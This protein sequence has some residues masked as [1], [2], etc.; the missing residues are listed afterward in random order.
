MTKSAKPQ[1]EAQISCAAFRPSQALATGQSNLL[2]VGPYDPH[3]VCRVCDTLSIPEREALELDLLPDD[4]E[5][6]SIALAADRYGI[7]QNAL[8]T[9][10]SGC[11]MRPDRLLAMEG[12][13]K[14]EAERLAR[15]TVNWFTTS[16]DK[17]EAAIDQMEARLGATVDVIRLRQAQ[18]VIAAR[19]LGDA[20]QRLSD[21]SA[22]E[23]LTLVEGKLDHAQANNIAQHNEQQD[24]TDRPSLA[25]LL[26]LRP[27]DR[28][29]DPL[30]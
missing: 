30:T 28:P 21:Q 4:K 17:A 27:V 25:S 1:T 20:V 9:H 13:G 19:F 8:R 2:A 11:L 29:V 23:R 14:V 24:T 15:R 6:L 10:L 26:K 3:R 5:P 16:M 18:A 7:S 22:Q 12:Q